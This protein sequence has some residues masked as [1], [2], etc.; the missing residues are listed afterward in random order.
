MAVPVTKV[1]GHAME[2][3][4]KEHSPPTMVPLK[5]EYFSNNRVIDDLARRE[6]TEQVRTQQSSE[7]YRRE[8]LFRETSDAGD[9]GQNQ[10]PRRCEAR[11][12][13]TFKVPKPEGPPGL[14]NGNERGAEQIGSPNPKNSNRNAQ[15]RGR[16]QT[17][18]GARNR[19]LWGKVRRISQ[20][21]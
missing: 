11:S 7:Y 9:S 5:V 2:W 14:K 21:P 20:Q 15:A 18:K 1:R 4:E 13:K 8:A 3:V 10:K 6:D 16:R 12:S 19:R 17:G